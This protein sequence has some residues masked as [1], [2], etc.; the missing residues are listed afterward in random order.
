MIIGGSGP[1]LLKKGIVNYGETVTIPLRHEHI[2]LLVEKEW[3][4]SSGAYR[5]HR[6]L[7]IAGAESNAATLTP[8][9]G[10]AYASSNSGVTNGYTTAPEV[11]ITPSANTYTVRYALYRLY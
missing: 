5:G 10:G 3:T 4:T 1:V 8:T 9:A 2:Y 7:V 6:M 11:T